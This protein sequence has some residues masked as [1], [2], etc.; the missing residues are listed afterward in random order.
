MRE[1][2]CRWLHSPPDQLL[3]GNYRCSFN[4][5][6]R[7][8]KACISS[9][10]TRFIDVAEQHQFG[11]GWQRCSHISNASSTALRNHGNA[12]A[13]SSRLFC[14]TGLACRLELAIAMYRSRYTHTY[15]G[16]WHGS[17]YLKPTLAYKP[18]CRTLGNT[19]TSPVPAFALI[20][21]IQDILSVLFNEICN[22]RD[23]LFVA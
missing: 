20:V 12:R 14:S 3:P 8:T 18:C 10:S 4:W 22:Y 15:L 7:M 1:E 13:T 5:D 17:S 9:A 19:S 11:F 6:R 23:Y 2:T 21:R 16:L